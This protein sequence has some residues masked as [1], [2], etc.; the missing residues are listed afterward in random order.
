MQSFCVKAGGKYYDLCSLNVYSNS[1][2]YSS[3]YLPT[4]RKIH[5]SF[6]ATVNKQSLT[7]FL[8][9][10]PASYVA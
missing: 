7:Y 2:S 4:A 5:R 8:V 9:L 3:Q 1:C 10:R 6:M